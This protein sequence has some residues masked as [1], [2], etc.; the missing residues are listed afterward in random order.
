MQ[1]KWYSDNRD[2]VK[3]SVLLVLARKYKAE[4]II[5]IAY[6]R[7]SDFGEIEIDGQ[8]YQMPSE[9]LPFFRAFKNIS[10]LSQLPCISIF[11]EIFENR[12]SYHQAAIEFIEGF[13]AERCVVFLDPDTGLEPKRGPD[14]KHVSNA[15]ARA[16]WDAIPS[17]WPYVLYQHLTNRAGRPWIEEKRRQFK[18]AIGVSQVGVASAQKIAN[19]VVL[20]YALKP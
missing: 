9:I 14:L 2:L 17:G 20:F 8:R 13:A 12:V 10:R 5:Q 3:W 11:P 7:Q 15:E 4:R 6:Y 16:V 1:D 19:D 18:D